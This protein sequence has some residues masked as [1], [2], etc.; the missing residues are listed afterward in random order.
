MRVDH[1]VDAVLSDE[2]RALATY[3]CQIGMGKVGIPIAIFVLED[4]DGVA[5]GSQLTRGRIDDERRA[6]RLLR[7]SP[8][9]VAMP[10]NQ[11]NVAHLDPLVD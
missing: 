5:S 2:L 4:M 1:H 7:V 3:E 6:L 11:E 9:G 10:H 8:A